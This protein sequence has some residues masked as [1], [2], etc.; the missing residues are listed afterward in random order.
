M[1][2]VYDIVGHDLRRRHTTSYVPYL[3]CRN[4]QCAYD[5]IKTYDVVRQNYNVV[6]LGGSRRLSSSS[7]AGCLTILVVFTG[8]L[9]H[10][11]VMLDR[12]SALDSD[13]IA[14][15]RFTVHRTRQER[16]EDLE[17]HR[18][19]LARSPADQNYVKH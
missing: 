9:Q 15:C 2:Y 17:A 7:A 19:K 4:L 3:R 8:T 12:R 14:D 6:R 18:Q 5:I 10:F 11:I 16:N 1:S 13:S